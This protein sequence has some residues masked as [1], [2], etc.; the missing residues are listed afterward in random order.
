MARELTCFPFGGYGPPEG[1]IPLRFVVKMGVFGSPRQIK[2]AET[3]IAIQADMW[4]LNRPAGLPLINGK[5][6][7]GVA[8]GDADEGR[9]W[10]SHSWERPTR[11]SRAPIAQ[12]I[13]VALAIRDTTR[14]G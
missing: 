12:T 4:P 5:V 7:C 11:R 6:R 2:R 3:F 1:N 8:A 14:L 10:K 13:S 9:V